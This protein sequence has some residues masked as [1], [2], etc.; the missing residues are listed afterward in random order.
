M[1][2]RQAPSPLNAAAPQRKQPAMLSQM[3]RDFTR[4]SRLLS[5]CAAYRRAPISS[6]RPM[7]EIQPRIFIH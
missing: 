2:Y 7:R 1:L 5:I 3:C 6:P 4:I